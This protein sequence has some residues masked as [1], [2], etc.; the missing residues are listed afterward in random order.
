MTNARFCIIPARAIGDKR[1]NR[2]DI[3]VLNALGMYGNTEGWSF[4][5]LKAIAEMIDAHKISVSKAI[6]KLIN[7][8]YIESRERY[9]KDR[10]RTSNEYRIIFDAPEM[11]TTTDV[12]MGDDPYPLADSLT[13]LSESAK[14]VLAAQLTLINEPTLTT[15]HTTSGDMK[16]E[17]HLPLPL[18]AEVYQ[19]VT[20]ILNSPMP[21]DGWPVQQWLE[22]GAIPDVD[23]YPT[24]KRIMAR[25]EH[26]PN[27]LKFFND[28]IAEAIRNRKKP[29]SEWKNAGKEPRKQSKLKQQDYRGNATQ[30]F[31]VT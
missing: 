19:L 6:S 8:G 23:I 7:C 14:G 22:W 21:F 16:D 3:M 11:Q 24:I 17:R 30:G 13:P 10:S 5:S 28:A 29:I 9:R 26:P 1:L 18:F 27:T 25:R 4:P 12:C 20:K 2:T 15:T 31:V